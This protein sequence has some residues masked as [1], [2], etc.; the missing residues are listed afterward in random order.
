MIVSPQW[1]TAG[2]T[3]YPSDVAHVGLAVARNTSSDEE[4]FR[5]VAGRNNKGFH[6][7]RTG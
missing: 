1:Y 6:K 7:D 2:K 5:V 3:K 4:V